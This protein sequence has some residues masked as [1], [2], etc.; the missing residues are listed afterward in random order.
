MFDDG[1]APDGKR[2]QE[3][4]KPGVVEA[5]DRSR[6]LECGRTFGWMQKLQQRKT[7]EADWSAAGSCR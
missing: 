1:Q 3:R 5:I 6:S 4:V 2:V 7:L